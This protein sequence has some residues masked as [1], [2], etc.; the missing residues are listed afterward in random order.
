[1]RQYV[2]EQQKR[3]A[4]KE[5]NT[6]TLIAAAPEL[7]TEAEE[8]V[9]VAFLATGSVASLKAMKAYGLSLGITFEEITQEDEK[10]E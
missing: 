6:A 5:E 3:L 10:N 2:M 1:M 4:E 8:L 9:H 7:A